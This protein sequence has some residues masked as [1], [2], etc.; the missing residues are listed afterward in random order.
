MAS[1]RLAQHLPSL[2]GPSRRATWRL[3]LARRAL[4]ATAILL[5]LHLTA[6]VAGS[7]PAA[8]PKAAEHTGPQLSIPLVLPVDHLAPGD[9]VGVYLPGQAEPIATDAH[10]V[11]TTEATS[12]R[13]VARITLRRNQIG[14]ILREMGADRAAEGGFVL[15]GNG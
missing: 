8:A 3:S 14:R 11:G 2:F 7:A 4:A 5:A 9:S 13:A 15:V 6:G 12:G 10:F 1:S